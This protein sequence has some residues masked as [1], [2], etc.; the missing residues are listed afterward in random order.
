MDGKKGGRKGGKGALGA[1]LDLL[2]APQLAQRIEGR[3]RAVRF[4]LFCKVDV[5]KKVYNGEGAGA[6]EIC[7][8]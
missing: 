3:K 2:T 5:R 6:Q 8:L 7:G 1:W 4:F